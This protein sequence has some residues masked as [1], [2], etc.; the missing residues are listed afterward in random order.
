MQ[1]AQIIESDSGRHYWP[2]LEPE[3]KACAKKPRMAGQAG[4]QR[5]SVPIGS[6]SQTQYR[7]GPERRL[8]YCLPKARQPLDPA[9][10]RIAGNDGAVNGADRAP[11]NALRPEIALVQRSVG[12]CLIGAKSKAA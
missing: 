2:R 1:Q 9:I 11:G 12:A 5:R 3:R 6:V 8:R 7:L 10:M 4:P